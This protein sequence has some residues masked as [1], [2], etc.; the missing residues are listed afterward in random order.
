MADNQAGIELLLSAPN[1]KSIMDDVIDD[2]KEINKQEE[3]AIQR[4]KELEEEMGKVRQRMKENAAENAN[5]K[6]NLEELKRAEQ[7]SA[8]Q[9][10]FNHEHNQKGI[11]ATIKAYFAQKAELKNLDKQILDVEKSLARLNARQVA[12]SL[13]ARRGN[14]A[15]IKE[16]AANEKQITSLGNKLSGL[17][18]KFNVTDAKLAGTAS[19]FGGAGKAMAA[20]GASAG[21]MAAAVV[22]GV[23]LVAAA[24]LALIYSLGKNNEEVQAQTE[25]IGKNFTKIKAELANAFAPVAFIIGSYLEKASQ[26]IS[27]WVTENREKIFDFSVK[28]AKGIAFF[29]GYAVAFFPYVTNAFQKMAKDIEISWQFLKNL[30]N[31]AEIFLGGL[32]KLKELQEERAKLTADTP[33]NPIDNGNVYADRAGKLLASQKE[34]FLTN[35]KLTKEQIDAVK[36]LREEYKK[37][38]K[39]INTQIEALDIKE[40]GP[41]GGILKKAEQAARDIE[42]QGE[43]AV[44][45]AK[46]LGKNQE[47]INEIRNAVAR[48]AQ[49]VR[50]DAITFL[51]EQASEIIDKVT[52]KLE[53]L[54]AIRSGTKGELAFVRE[55]EAQYKDLELYQQILETKLE[56]ARNT[57]QATDEILQQLEKGQQALT[58]LSQQSTLDFFSNKAA[59]QLLRNKESVEKATKLL[60][61]TNEKLKASL[62]QVG[63]GNEDKARE[64]LVLISVNETELAIAQEKIRQFENSFELFKKTGVLGVIQTE[65]QIRVKVAGSAD[66]GIKGIKPGA[67][68]DDVEPAGGKRGPNSG[69]IAKTLNDV[70]SF[71]EIAY[72]AIDDIVLG[73]IDRQI[74]AIDRLVETRNKSVDDL[75]DQLDREAIFKAAGIAND[76]QIVKKQLDDEIKLRDASEKKAIELAEKR[77]KT[78]RDIDTG[79]QLSSITTAIANVFA[80]LTAGNPLGVILASANVLAML[81]AFAAAKLKARKLVTA[82]KGSKR[83]GETFGMLAPGEGY[84]DS[85]GRN[86]G[87]S[88]V[89]D[90]GEL[91]GFFGGDE[92]AHKQSVSKKHRKGFDYLNNNEGKFQNINLYETLKFLENNNV[93]QIRFPEFSNTSSIDYERITRKNQ[94]LR[95]RITVVN[96]NGITKADLEAAVA[97]ALEKQTQDMIAYHESRPYYVSAETMK[98]YFKMNSKSVKHITTK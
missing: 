19:R 38:T 9:A 72:T 71:Y 70:V 28:V 76:Y 39:E 18:E 32:D 63:D 88:V 24:G 20:L 31:P 16:Y 10:A 60:L 50:D 23:A 56:H 85:P 42:A 36:K 83:M 69:K 81:T 66:A 37:L 12:I 64:I 45:V 80:S 47:T 40:A 59:E 46:K 89:D 30:L 61:E 1:V 54:Q 5:I 53:D 35:T 51:D 93:P 77:A 7:A 95:D 13:S 11:F 34:A 4:T 22:A 78:Q 94:K 25:R 41:F 21:A 90:N 68:G 65:A 73:S 79:N 8:D 52:A 74:E 33:I 26:K 49:A 57:G 92:Y 14:S 44:D 91:R 86:R 29:V 67:T 58:A 62:G 48:L 17:N 82:Y 97:K 75:S 98:D 6:K 55:L 2:W 43:L 27:K 15:A 96:Q 84:D 3:L 87:L